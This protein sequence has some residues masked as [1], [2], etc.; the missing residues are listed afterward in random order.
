[1]AFDLADPVPLTVQIYDADSQPSNASAVSLTITLPDGTTTSPTVS[2]PT[3]GRYQADYLA[4]LAG[5]YTARWVATGLNASAY[6]EAFDVRESAPGYIVSLADAKAHLNLTGVEFDEE[7]RAFIEAVTPVVEDV[8]G[9]VVA[10]TYTEVHSGG[11]FLV[12]GYSPVISL[13]SLAPVLTNGITYE[14][15]D[16]DVDTEVGVVRRLDGGRF[17]GPLRA[18]YKAGRPIVPANISQG[19]KEVI[20]HMWETQRGHSGAR[21]GFG[22]EEFVTTGSGYTVPRRVMELL[23]PHKRAPLVA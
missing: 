13:T 20:R 3:T 17:C 21:P 9:P 8:V 19:A 11:P 6:V 7:L 12:L 10:R 1:V 15:A 22:E 5:R 16:L 23:A 18:V 4:P 2:N 14:V